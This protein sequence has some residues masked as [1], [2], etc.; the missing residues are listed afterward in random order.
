MYAIV[1]RIN[2]NEILLWD[3]VLDHTNDT[4]EPRIFDTMPSTTIVNA[5]NAFYGDGW[6]VAKLKHT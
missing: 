2:R 6:V 4:R 5:V 1:K 3:G